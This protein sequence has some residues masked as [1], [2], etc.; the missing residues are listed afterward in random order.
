MVKKFI[1]DTCK[2]L[3]LPR[4]V[5]EPQSALSTSYY[6]RVGKKHVIHIRSTTVDKK[7]AA[8]HEIGH[9]FLE[10]YHGSEVIPASKFKALFGKRDI[11][12][13]GLLLA[14][15]LLSYA[16]GVRES[17][18]S[19]YAEAHPEEDWA[20]TFSWVVSCKRVPS[21]SDELLKEKIAFVRKCIKESKR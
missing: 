19:A 17:F 12:Y 4:P 8:L 20:E 1:L 16:M 9:F 21:R 14:V 11:P 13:E 10:V 6:S 18:V 2:D 7:Y 15:P 3:N 5:V